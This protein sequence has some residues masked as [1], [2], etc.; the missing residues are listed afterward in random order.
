[1]QAPAVPFIFVSG[2]LG[3]EIAVEALKDGAT[4]Y[5]TKQRLERLPAIVARA[6]EERAERVARRAAEETLRLATAASQVFTWDYD[7][8]HDVLRWDAQCKALF[9]PPADAA[10]NYRDSFLPGIHPDDR[11]K[12]DTA[13]QAALQPDGRGG[14]DIEF[15]TVGLRDGVE[16]WVAAKGC[17]QFEDGRAVRFVGTVIDITD[18][19]R[20]YAAVAASEPR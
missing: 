14:Y 17:G 2:T 16:R 9:G 7:P 19:K 20:A 18:R 12:A 13:V 6:V 15:R 10:V 5:V 4:D 1:M 8:L 11:A 3:E